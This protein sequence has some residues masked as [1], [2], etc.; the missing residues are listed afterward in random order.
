MERHPEL[1]AALK[2]TGADLCSL[3]AALVV[4]EVATK[5]LHEKDVRLAELEAELAEANEVIESAGR[6]MC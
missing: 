4:E 5:L 3:T 1:A 6:G 2:A